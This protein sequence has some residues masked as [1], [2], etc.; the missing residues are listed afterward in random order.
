MLLADDDNV[1]L[2]DPV[3]CPEDF[4]PYVDSGA[5]FLDADLMRACNRAAER[6]LRSAFFPDL[7][8]KR[9]RGVGERVVV[10]SSDQP[11]SAKLLP[12]SV[13][14]WR[15]VRYFTR[16]SVEDKF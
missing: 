15:K 7:R 1:C 14:T 10:G 8:S 11:P 9:Y 4:E 2:A 12:A 13:S 5:L 3:T 16:R 6:R